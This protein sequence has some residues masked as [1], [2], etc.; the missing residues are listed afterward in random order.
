VGSRILPWIIPALILA[1]I[2][3]G[4][5]TSGVDLGI[6]M[7]IIWVLANGTLAA[8][9]AAIALGHPLTILGSFLAA[10]ITSMNPTIGVGMVSGIME[11]FFRKPRVRD[12]EALQDDVTSLRGWYRNRISRILL[13]F[14]FSS[15][16]SSVG[17]FYALPRISLLLG[18]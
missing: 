18:S 1:V 5:I 13:V 15:L 17:T 11:Y 12:M 4:F 2:A 9:G 3:T 10:P 16:G 8:L 7:L 6:R 14:F